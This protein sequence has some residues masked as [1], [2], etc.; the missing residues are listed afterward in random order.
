MYENVMMVAMNVIKT[1]PDSNSDSS[2]SGSEAVDENSEEDSLGVM[3]PDVKLET[4]EDIPDER[5]GVGILSVAPRDELVDVN[6]L[7]PITCLAVKSEMK[8]S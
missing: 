2:L 1:E 7:V 8:V 6:H 4:E 3:L 5:T